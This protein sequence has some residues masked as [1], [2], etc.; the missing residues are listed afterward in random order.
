MKQ[1]RLFADLWVGCAGSG[2]ED[3]AKVHVPTV[4]GKF[5]TD[6][7]GGREIRN[8]AGNRCTMNAWGHMDFLTTKTNGKEDEV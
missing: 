2:G 3:R 7:R 6:T 4:A 8:A 1:R 5:G